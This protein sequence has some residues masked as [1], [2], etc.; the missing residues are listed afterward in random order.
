MAELPRNGVEARLAALEEGAR[1]SRQRTGS[2]LGIM[3]S[4]AGVVLGIV[5]AIGGIVSTGLTRE[6]DRQDA[7]RLL[8]DGR[9]QREMRDL[10]SA[11]LARAGG[12]EALA[13][14]RADANAQRLTALETWS[15]E[16]S[17]TSS[18]R[19]GR[20]DEQARALER[21]VFGGDP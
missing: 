5:G 15:F 12:V 19:L 17:R 10:D 3:A 9:L 21:V 1:E 16:H 18:D 7:E 8:L 6:M 2:S 13:N 4:W 11:G 14:E 20:L